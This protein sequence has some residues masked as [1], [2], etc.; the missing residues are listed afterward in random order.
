MPNRS[1]LI[2][3][4][5]VLLVPFA[6]AAT[7]QMENLDRGVVAIRQED[8]AIFVGWRLLGTDPQDLAFNVYRATDSAAPV[9]LNPEQLLQSTAARELLHGRGD[10]RTA[11]RRHHHIGRPALNFAAPAAL[12]PLRPRN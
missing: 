9:K 4:L 8:D 7:R 5:N 1:V 10:D 6:L 11:G 3:A 2:L 12:T